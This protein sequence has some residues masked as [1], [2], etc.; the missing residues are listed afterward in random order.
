MPTRAYIQ[1]LL[2]LSAAA[3]HLSNQDG[4]HNHHFAHEHGKRGGAW[5]VSAEK[6]ALLSQSGNMVLAAVAAPVCAAPSTS[7]RTQQ[8]AAVA[9]CRL[10]VRPFLAGEAPLGHR[11]AQ[12]RSASRRLAPG[13]YAVAAPEG[14][15]QT[16]GNGKVAKVSWAA[17]AAAAA[18]ACAA[19][20]HG[21]ARACLVSMRQARI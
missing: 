19:C 4:R 14:K 15:L 18:A 21:A 11:S 13:V 3:R 6:Q 16:Y 10:R 7:G 20:A 2:P 12:P 17:A 9:P 1:H 8:Q 5:F